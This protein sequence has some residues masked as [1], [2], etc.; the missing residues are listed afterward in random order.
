MKTL[1][2]ELIKTGNE[3]QKRIQELEQE[4]RNSRESQ[5]ETRALSVHFGFAD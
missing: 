5:K 3:L 1:E 4:I 2:E